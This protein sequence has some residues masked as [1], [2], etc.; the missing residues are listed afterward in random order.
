MA[1]SDTLSDK[2]DTA[3]NT[4]PANAQLQ[5]EITIPQ[6]ILT[7]PP[8]Q[9]SGADSIDTSSP[10]ALSPKSVPHK[11]S[12]PASSTVVSP[13]PLPSP[14]PLTKDL[15]QQKNKLD[16]L[17]SQKER[18]RRQQ[19]QQQ[20]QQQRYTDFSTSSAVDERVTAGLGIS[21]PNDN[22]GSWSATGLR[23][24]RP[25]SSRL[26]SS[27]RSE[28]EKSAFSL[29][30][31]HHS[32]WSFDLHA[33][34]SSTSG[35]SKGHHHH[36]R[37]SSSNQHQTS[38]TSVSGSS[39]RN[40]VSMR[41]YSANHRY[42]DRHYGQQ[43]AA[44]YFERPDQHLSRDDEQKSK[45]FLL[46][47][48]LHAVNRVVNSRAP[49]SKQISDKELFDFDTRIATDDGENDTPS[50]ALNEKP[51]S[52]PEPVSHP[53]M[54]PATAT[55]TTTN[56]H[57]RYS[58][59]SMATSLDEKSSEFDSESMFRALHN[60]K[61]LPSLHTIVNDIQPTTPKNSTS[62]SDEILPN[63]L[64]G[65]SLG[66]FGPTNKFRIHVWRFIRISIESICKI[67]AYG[68]IIP[69]RP[70][71]LSLADQEDQDQASKN[72]KRNHYAYLNSFGNAF[73]AISVVGYWADLI[74]M[75]YKYPYLSLF[76]SLASLRP[77]RLLSMLRGTAVIL[78]SLE[79]S[80]DLLLAVS[81]LIFFF[82]L[83]FALVGLIS[84][85][86]VFSR[87]CY[88]TDADNSLQLV[89]PA[90]YCS[91]YMNDTTVLGAYNIETG[92][93][94][95]PGYHGY[96]CAA[97]QICIE[98]PE[99]NPNYGYVNFD[100]IFFSFLNVYTF[101]SLELWTDLMYQTQEADST[102]AALYYC[103]GVYIV[104]FVLT[105]LLF[106]VVT[107]A[108]ARVRAES[109]VSAFTAKKKGY[110]VLRDA[111]GLDDE[112]M[113]MFDNPPDD[114][115]K[116]VTRLKLR[117]WIVRMV[118]NRLF[119][120]FGGFLVLF[121]LV[122]MCMRSFY[123]SESMLELVDNA[124]TAFTFVFA[125]EI[126]LRMVG[127]ASWMSFWSA[128]TNLFDLF[129]VIST[130]VIQLPIIQDSWVYK[131]LTVFQILRLYRLFICIPR[132]RRLLSAALGTGESVLYVMVFLILAT[133][134]CS[135]IF[136]QM[137]GG[138][139]SD[140]VSVD[141]PENR[142]DT[143][144]ESFVSL[145]VVYTSERWTDALYNAMASQHGQGSIYAAIALS[146]YFAF[147][148][149]IMSGLYIAVVL[150]N[151]ELSD[152]YIRHYQIKDFIHRHRF[153]NKDRTETILLKL[154]R[155]FY[156]FN[157]NKNV[158]ISKLPANL[159][160]PLN[161]SDLTE[162]LTDLPKKRDQD[163][164]EQPSWIERK[165]TVFFSSIRRRIPFLRKASS[166][167]SA[168]IN[169]FIQ[170]TEEMP[171]DYDM[172]AAEENREAM[173]ENAPVVNSL[174]M[175][176]NRSRFR[177]YCKKL[178]GS[179]NDGQA[180]K[181]NLFNWMV[182]ACVLVS[183][184]M[185]ILDE[186]STRLIR[187][188]TSKQDIYDTIEVVLSI[189]FIVEVSIRIVADGLLL[190]PNGYLRNH[191][192][193]LDLC[194]ILLNIITIFMSSEEV[195]RGLSTFR[196]LRILR[197]IRYFNGVRDIFVALFYA[198]P[199]MFDALI[200]TFLV[201]VPF[202]VYGVNIFGGLMWICN[203]ET[204]GSRGECIGEYEL[205]ISSDDGLDLNVWVP[206]VWQNPQ[207]GFISYD[208]FPLALQHLFSLTST[209]GWVDSMFSAMSTPHE[210]DQ[211]PTFNWY[212]KTVYHGIFY[213]IFMIISQG[214]M[215]LFVGVIIEKFK[216]R[217]GITTLTTAQ[218]KYIDLQRLLSSV[219]P[220][221]KVFRP[222]SKI[223]QICHDM[224]IKKHGKF[225]R[226]MM[227]VICLNIVAIASEFQNEPY[228][229]EQ[230]Q[231]YSYLGFTIIYVAECIIKLLGL[232]WKKWIR[233]KWN[234]FDCIIAS[235]A[236]LLLILRFALP[237]L[238]TLRV[239]RYCLVLA[240]FRLGEGIDSLQTLYHTIA[241]SMPSIIQVSAVFMVAMCLFAM[242]FM[243]FFGLTKY[244][245]YGGPHSNFRDYGN[246]LLLLVRATTGEAWNA[247]LLDYTVQY[248]N[249][250]RSHNY[251]EDD[252][253][254]PFWAYFLFDIFYIVCTHI[255]MNLFT[256]VIISNFEYAYETRTRFTNIT[257]ADL[258]M[259]KH[260]W[261]D[262][263]TKGTGYIQ[264]EDVAKLLRKFTGRFRFRIYDDQ[265]TVDNILK[266]SHQSFDKH[267]SSFTK[268]PSAKSPS[269][270]SPGAKSPGAKSLGRSPNK[271][272]KSPGAKS[273]HSSQ[274]AEAQPI[275]VY[276]I[277]RCLG[278]M[279]VEQV[280]KNRLEYNLYFKEILR[281]ETSKGIPFAS[282]LTIMSYR[283][284]D[285]STSL[286]LDPLIARLEKLEQLTQEYHLEKA[287][288][289]FLAQIQKRRFVRQ[290]WMKRDEDEVKKLGVTN[291]SHFEFGTMARGTNNTFDSPI[292]YFNMASDINKTS[293]PVPRIVI[294][295]ASA[296]T[297]LS[298]PISVGSVSVPV[299]PIS[300]FSV[301]NQY[302]PSYSE[303]GL[304]LM[305]A[306]GTNSVPSSPNT[307]A[308]IDST[309][310]SVFSSA[311]SPFSPIPAFS[312][313]TRQTWL[314]IDGNVEMPTE[315]SE[316]IM[317]SM[318]HSIWSD[319]LR[320]EDL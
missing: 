144:W 200:F 42:M 47:F 283:F 30:S 7:K 245:V 104:A 257:K 288:G 195:P 147:G 176:S 199:L 79:T 16:K 165:L 320:D 215:Q 1:E 311:L 250:N 162:L 62:L 118:N 110:P 135:T 143:F 14:L 87:R 158:Q 266:A 43:Q 197:L 77:L 179:S 253:G 117:W 191:W 129:L 133:A 36:H 102:V 217:N 182:M 116:G 2:K 103:L 134:L 84:F 18:Q 105:F 317:D 280:R 263:D 82:L 186:P 296:N 113:W 75:V 73:D 17:L 172:I 163:E 185:V 258:R 242:L 53:I 212:S 168:P 315:V 308:E 9:E 64:Q 106:A 39:N 121:D 28:P 301:E 178:V 255:F 120:Y 108:F 123:A 138:D 125:L 224:V 302:D 20:Q 313:A 180:E 291:A 72:W 69:P 260:A 264:K 3:R 67:I 59:L 181:H 230:V 24:R 271:S 240:A 300:T 169:P 310:R 107:S 233:S 85:Q 10:H 272:K 202:A 33:F 213:I 218:R 109:A 248:P 214:T 4:P 161:R 97:G 46:D 273:G 164:L 206:R 187:K 76:K 57:N 86:G 297:E 254:S 177:Y 132:V 239:E 51:M 307:N 269:A 31:Q 154:F 15:L 152:D 40:S 183:I 66:I 244:G 60:E 275:N 149:Y 221:I 78:K 137:F 23:S 145:I 98:N 252:C 267:L 167:K 188:D 236:L 173:K 112:A 35:S 122:F 232:G 159:T 148:R 8:T 92:K 88:Y 45:Y 306:P 54:T 55:T 284:I 229:L 227:S 99:H 128:K 226:L 21:T 157:E 235:C 166:I 219:R 282:V 111:E 279:D 65:H 231:D 316:G 203:D 139:Y 96:L 58:W 5:S 38:G 285:I 95:Y 90:L 126:L 281:S 127:A 251:L 19:Q 249:C 174:F 11:P 201:L 160:A 6:I 150:E 141:E 63:P 268:S 22:G 261:A 170:D 193:Q 74:V 220:T 175:F 184:L 208:S 81:G 256:A 234:W 211:Q 299:S 312:P 192:N 50:D 101:V 196:S 29:S 198:F 44:P 26:S 94:S 142:F 274:P 277:N 209:E 56:K 223:R 12:P 205:N 83:L 290:L 27:N 298:S 204:V 309:G 259:F 61:K 265:H 41:A 93:S 71:K 136:M 119:F 52:P 25:S 225:N 189:V 222:D 89:E 292:N 49:E 270:K 32:E 305:V 319:L 124:E 293:P 286:T 34:R 237:D 318:N 48:L 115:G 295:N 68:L 131:Y 278:K 314:L 80:W 243:E 241:K 247:L 194:V 262:I 276:E 304:S 294:D 155:P 216:E 171:E 70:P 153:K 156:Y 91:G 207:N 287:A 151:F 100:T 289:F 228:W 210:P 114:L 37:H 146:L 140:I 246:A 130:C 238:W 303:G 190:T 13:S